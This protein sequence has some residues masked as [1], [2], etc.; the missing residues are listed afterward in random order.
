MHQ[1]S[2]FRLGRFCLV[3]P[4]LASA[5]V[6]A[7]EAIPEER[8][9]VVTATR[10][11]TPIDEVLASVLVIDRDEIDRSLAGDAADLLRF[12]AGL[13]VARN[14]GP[15]QS[16]SLFIRGAESNHTLVMID[17]VRINPGTIGQPALQ[18]I[19]PE[20]IERI[21][22]VK[23]PRS[24]LYGTDAIGGVVNIVTRRGSRDGWTA[25]LGYG[26]YETRE[27]SLTGGVSGGAGSLDLG[28]SWI[29]SA[30]FPTQDGDTTDRG[31]DNLSVNL[32]GRTTL[33]SADLTARLWHAEGNTEY[34]DLFVTPIDQDQD[35]ENSA[36]SI[37]AALPTGDRGRLSVTAG[38]MADEIRQNRSPDFLET[39]R[40]TLDAQQDWRLNARHA[41][42]AGMQYS[43]EDA[44][45]EIFGLTFDETT[46]IWNLFVQDQLDYGA[47][48]GVLAL[49]FTD[50]ETAGSDLTWNAEYA[51]AFSRNTELVLSGGTGFRAPDATDRF[52]FFGNPDLEPERSRSLAAELRHTTGERHHFR[53][54]VYENRIEDLIEFVALPVEPFGALRNVAEARIPGVEA[55][56]AYGGEAWSVDGALALADPENRSTGE[57]LPRRPK[58]SATLAVQRRFA[59]FDVGLNVLAAGDRPDVAFPAAVE[60]ASYVLIDLT[61]GW[62]ITDRLSLRA[63]VENLLDEDYELAAGFNTP[64]RGVYL[65]LRYAQSR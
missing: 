48:R 29:D 16:T 21:E 12:H 15:G 1:L 64:G 53:L 65:A 35:F 14:G 11:A 10:V 31:F 25:E 46:R 49:G 13:E 17:G 22:V 3:L 58:E 47:H 40:V 24:A 33:R 45:S 50:H 41:L 27:A 57:P 59:S 44:A 9:V 63:R 23:G 37:G 34:S 4:L 26:D 54:G 60:L 30:G 42:S 51:Y 19:A 28:V 36:A 52:G 32:G 18:N 20:L 61:A 43:D 56:Y 6:L 5:P 7:Q 39:H 8:R 38:Y 55:G 2:W 62:Q